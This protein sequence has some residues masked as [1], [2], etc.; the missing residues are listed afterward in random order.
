MIWQPLQLQSARELTN[1]CRAR[2]ISMVRYEPDAKPRMFLD[3]GLSEFQ[4]HRLLSRRKRPSGAR[5]PVHLKCRLAIHLTDRQDARV[6]YD[7]HSVGSASSKVSVGLRRSGLLFFSM[8]KYSQCPECG[9]QNPVV[10]TS[11]G[12]GSHMA[13]V[14]TRVISTVCRDDSCDWR[15]AFEE[16]FDGVRWAEIAE[17]S[18]A[19][20][21]S[22]P[23]D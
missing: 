9:N 11:R 17:H 6:K 4:R 10:E 13:F 2:H 16:G 15:S 12:S 3:V 1:T 18:I 8:R 23:H 22:S 20:R 5:R 7:G 19:V 21:A 14:K